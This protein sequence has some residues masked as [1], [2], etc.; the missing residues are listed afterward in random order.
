MTPPA[1]LGREQRGV[2]RGA[3][4]AAAVS[5]IVILAGW[6]SRDTIVARSDDPLARL[7]LALRLDLALLACL[8]VA[9]GRVAHR[10]YTSA[11]D[12][13]GGA[14]ATESAAVR[15]SRAQLQNTLEQ[16]A[17]ALPAHLALATLLPP[18]RMGVIAALVLLFVAG[19]IAFIRGYARGGPGRAF[20]F[21]LT[22]YPTAAALLAA[23]ALA[24]G[25]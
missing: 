25:N 11:E 10:R 5:L 19:R 8:F 23:A 24:I 12:I 17:L 14:A 16:V 9:I 21:G 2:V 22:F 6:L 3:A 20:G 4:I 13:G 18:D 1:D 15:E 7:L